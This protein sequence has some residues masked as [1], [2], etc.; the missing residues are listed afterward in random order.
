MTMRGVGVGGGTTVAAG[1]GA[2]T[3]RGVGVG[4]LVAELDPQA[5][6]VSVIISSTQCRTN[7]PFAKRRRPKQARVKLA[8][9]STAKCVPCSASGKNRQGPRKDGKSIGSL[10]E[11]LSIQIEAGWPEGIHVDPAASQPCHLR[12]TQV[13]ARINLP[14]L[15]Q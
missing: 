15:G 5:A 11:K 14:D 12:M 10:S 13:H 2:A 8:D 6:K 3:E 9:S 4:V 7:S 1:D